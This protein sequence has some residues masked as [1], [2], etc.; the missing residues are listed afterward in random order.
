MEFHLIPKYRNTVVIEALKIK[1]VH[2]SRDDEGKPVTKL[3]FEDSRFGPMTLNQKDLPR[4]PMFVPGAYWARL[5]DGAIVSYSAQYIES[6]FM[7]AVTLTPE[8]LKNVRAVVAKDLISDDEIRS[9][10]QM[11]LTELHEENQGVIGGP[12][13]IHMQHP[14]RLAEAVT[15]LVINKLAAMA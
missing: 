4:M 9:V 14:A 6:S 15:E 13:V 12:D 1:E 10:N 7:P 2:L 3:V 5:D 11:V 8:L